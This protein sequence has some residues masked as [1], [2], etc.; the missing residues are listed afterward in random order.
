MG[1]F[2]MEW[3]KAFEGIVLHHHGVYV[4]WR[5]YVQMSGYTSKY[6][7][8]RNGTVSSDPSVELEVAI[9]CGA[10]AICP[11]MTFDALLYRYNASDVT[12]LPDQTYKRK[13]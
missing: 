3:G 13:S 8:E 2:D 7:E 1:S 5:F 9:L 11:Q 10:S 12:R 6:F 4:I